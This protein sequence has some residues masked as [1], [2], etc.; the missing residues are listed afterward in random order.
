MIKK[1]VY[2]A[3]LSIL[4]ED[5]TLNIELTIDHAV[6]LIKNGLHGV[7]FFWFYRTKPTYFF[8]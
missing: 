7:F 6:N 5:K 4:N 1:G 2:A 3:S 8:S